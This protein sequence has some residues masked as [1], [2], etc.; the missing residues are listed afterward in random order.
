MKIYRMMFV[1]LVVLAAA[2]TVSAGH[3]CAHI[4][5]CCR[6]SNRGTE[7][8]VNDQWMRM[9]SYQDISQVRDILQKI[10]D[11][12]IKTVIID[13]TNASQWTRLWDEFEPMLNNIEKVC[14]EK[15]MQFFMFIGAVLGEDMKQENKITEDAFVFWNRMAEKIW[16]TW[17]QKPVYRKY[18]FGDDRPMLLVFQP[19]QSYWKKYDQAPASEKNYLSKFRIGTTQ[20]NSPIVPGASDGWGYRNF[21]QNDSGTVRFVSPNGGVPPQDWFR[22]DKAEWEKRVRWAAEAEQYSVYGSYDDTCD[23]IFWGIADT[24]KSLRPDHKYPGNQPYLYYDVLKKVLIQNA[25]E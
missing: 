14:V 25:D 4:L 1:L 12:G 23:G 18:G 20:V 9:H 7:F 15:D 22:I 17:A 10:K 5:V 21:S 3:P 19:S 2:S 13:M 6:S 11:A 8:L 16:N 24:A